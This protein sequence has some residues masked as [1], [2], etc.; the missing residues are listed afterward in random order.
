MLI[1]RLQRSVP[2]TACAATLMCFLLT[3]A[4]L[5]H[6]EHQHQVLGTAHVP[7]TC[8]PEAQTAFDEAMKLQHSFWHTA[9]FEQFGAVLKHD[10]N[11]VMAYWGQAFSLLDNPFSPPP[12]KNLK[13]G[14]A[15]LEEAQA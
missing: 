2:S 8:S 7:V 5:A 4:T 9:A 3:T 10:P 1:R 14:L 6:S 11:C 12:A 13:R 15:L